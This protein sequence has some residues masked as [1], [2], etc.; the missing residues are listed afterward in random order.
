M[1]R[2][3]RHP[4]VYRHAAG[5]GSKL[6]RSGHTISINNGITGNSSARGLASAAAA[7]LPGIGRFALT[8]PSRHHPH[9]IESNDQI[10]MSS[11]EIN[12]NWNNNRETREIS[13][14]A[15]PLSSDAIRA[16]KAIDYITDHLRKEEEH[17]THRDDWR[18]VAMVIDRLLLLIFFGITLGGTLGVL[19]SAPHVFESVDQRAVLRRLVQ[20]YHSGG[21]L[22]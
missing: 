4:I 8:G 2:P 19:L 6:A 7:I 1:R 12:G 20:L 15:F 16:I 21:Q 17:K 9:C 10:E 3:R 22:F 13:S 18:Y 5:Y 11:R 14:E